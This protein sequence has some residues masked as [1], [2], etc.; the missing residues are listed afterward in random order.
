MPEPYFGWAISLYCTALGVALT[1]IVSL[2]MADTAGCNKLKEFATPGWRI[3]LRTYSRQYD[4]DW[5]QASVEAN[6]HISNREKRRVEMRLQT[7]RTIGIVAALVVL[8]AFAG[9]SA[10]G[11]GSS[12]T[13]GPGDT[14]IEDVET[15]DGEVSLTG[16]VT[17][18]SE[19]G[20]FNIDDGTGTAFVMA[21]AEDIEEGDCV[22]V[23]GSV[24]QSPL[25]EGADVFIQGKNITAA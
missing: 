1:I 10:L 12:D 8:S 5:S 6:I 9:C 20:A 15:G 23:E 16:E 11:G 2:R 14:K 21:A 25:D 7:K 19:D 18:A 17:N 22:T 3:S 4:V 13:C 24:V